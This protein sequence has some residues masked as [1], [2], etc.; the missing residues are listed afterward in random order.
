MKLC[1]RE[2]DESRAYGLG[3]KGR[4]VRVTLV[5][6]CYRL[7]D[8]EEE[9]D[10]VLYR[11]LEVASQSQVLVLMKDFNHLD[12]FRRNH[13]ARHKQHR[14]FLESTDSNFMAQV[15]KEPTRKGVLLDIC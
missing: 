1:L 10:K 2:D 7:P 5:G 8:G 9:A 13:K 6:D 11:Q 4:L 3:L 12:T 14:R 15:A